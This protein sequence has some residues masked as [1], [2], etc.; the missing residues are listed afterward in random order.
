MTER[1]AYTINETAGLLG[2]SAMTIR[3]YIRAGI[4]RGFRTGEG[5]DWR[6]ASTEIDRFIQQQ[7]DKE[8]GKKD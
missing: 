1:R 4:L 8:H 2:V 5:G 3:R 6:I 7:M